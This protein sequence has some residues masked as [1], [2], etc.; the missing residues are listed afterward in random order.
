MVQSASVFQVKPIA[1]ALGAEVEGV[2]LSRPLD[3]DALGKIEAA[4]AEHEVLFFRDQDLSPAAHHAFA[5]LFGPLQ[6]HPAYPHVEGFPEITILESDRDNPSKIEKWHTD[7]T[8]RPHPPLGSILRARV[9]PET[10]G[11][12]L[13]M[14]LSAAYDALS[15]AM[16]AFLGDLQAEHSFEHG[17][18][19]SL[20]EPGGR[21]RLADAVAANPPVEH[22]VVRVHPVS[23]RRCLFVNSLF[24][25]RIL[26]LTPEESDA[27]LAFLYAHMEREEFACRFAWKSNSVA[28]WDNRCTQHRPV[29][30][31]WPA[32]RRLERITIDGDAPYGP[33]KNDDT[34]PANSSRSVPP[35]SD[36]TAS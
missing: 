18:R 22:P 25:T 8:F 5:M 2:D 10:K 1:E 35:S 17:F 36:S 23:G 24:T 27:V 34:Q 7:M 15:P 21:E 9:V 29:N 31:Y 32:H 6:T 33:R 26:G 19:E 4:L 13:W 3:A 30:D 28:F 20:A 16:R 12:T 11:D 14:S